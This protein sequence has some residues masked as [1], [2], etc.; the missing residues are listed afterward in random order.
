MKKTKPMY[1]RH[2]RSLLTTIG[3]AGIISIALYF[4]LIVPV[5]EHNA[6]I[7]AFAAKVPPANVV[8]SSSNIKITDMGDKGKVWDIA[9]TFHET[10]GNCGSSGSGEGTIIDSEGY[11]WMHANYSKIEWATIDVN[12]GDYFTYYWSLT[13]KNNEPFSNGELRMEFKFED[14]GERTQVFEWTG[15]LP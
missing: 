5:L 2:P 14:E 12:V 13:T 11:I 4:L 9:V 15:Q 7:K 3:I 6:E 10:T 8:V 1:Y